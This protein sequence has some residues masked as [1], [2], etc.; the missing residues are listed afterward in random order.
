VSHRSACTGITITSRTLVHRSAS[1]VTDTSTTA[2]SWV[3]GRG[4]TGDTVTAGENIASEAVGAVTAIAAVA[5][6]NVDMHAEAHSMET[7][8]GAVVRETDGGKQKQER[9]DFRFC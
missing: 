6:T 4:A 7:T 8:A 5:E 9:E 3:S 1:M 2:S